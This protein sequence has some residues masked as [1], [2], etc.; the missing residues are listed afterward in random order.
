MKP[1][2]TSGIALGLTLLW[3]PAN[4]KEFENLDFE[5]GVP[6]GLHDVVVSGVHVQAGDA[7]KML[8]GWQV[9]YDGV[10]TTSVFYDSNS[11]GV[12][13]GMTLSENSAPRFQTF[14]GRYSLFV[15][16]AL[17][18]PDQDPGGRTMSISQVGVIPRDAV[19]L[20]YNSTNIHLD[21][22]VNG[23]PLESREGYA[24]E[25]FADLRKFAGSEVELTFSFQ[26]F[27]IGRFDSVEFTSVPEPSSFALLV[28]GMSVV[29]LEVRRR[30]KS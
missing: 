11:G 8:P 3:V 29:L 16:A 15:W 12:S 23:Q 9:K 30:R 25:E 20:R 21:V 28:G 13:G 6:S 26:P 22:L 5:S 27:Y 17:N 2:G 14:Y 7:A 19:G 4:A 10:V 24:G 1:F 18:F